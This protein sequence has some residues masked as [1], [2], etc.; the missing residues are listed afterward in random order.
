ML[1]QLILR[2]KNLNGS[3]PTCSI[4]VL[5]VCPCDV[6]EKNNTDFFKNETPSPKN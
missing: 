6:F 4:T 2:L 3:Y 1:L 5:K